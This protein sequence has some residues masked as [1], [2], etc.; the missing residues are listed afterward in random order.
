MV[1]AECFKGLPFE[2]ESF[3]VEKYDSCV[4]TCRYI[5]IFHATRN[6]HY[7]LIQEKDNLL[8]VI[9]YDSREDTVTCLN[10]L[11]YLKQDTIDVFTNHIFNNY[12][13]IKTIEF[14]S[15]YSNLLAEKSILAL[16]S[17]DFI[18]SLPPSLD[19]Y[20]KQLGSST[21]A[22]VRKHKNKFLK[23]NPQANF[24][25]KTG[26]EIDRNLIDKIISLNFNRII[27]KG[28][29][30]NVNSTHIDNFH[31]YS[32]HYGCV[33]YIEVN[34]SIIAGSIAYM[35][36]KSMYSYFLAHDNDYSNYNAGQLCM[37]YLI[38]VAIEKGFTE[39][40]LLWGESEYKTRFL[41]KPRTMY[42]YIIFKSFSYNFI[43]NKTK[44]YFSHLLYDFKRS[45]YALPLKS[46][47]RYFKKKNFKQLN[48]LQ[49]L[50]ILL[51]ERVLY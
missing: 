3:L 50:L 12:P 44:E 31:Q 34:G 39:F 40:H 14:P 24:V 19:D 5:A 15:S 51:F 48:K 23:E 28:Q 26:N 25:T 42:S 18:I 11:S 21:R 38:Q 30:P 46:A 7:M 8:D 17:D 2:Y 32:Q 13:N 35:S 41:A 27:S 4:T 16:R 37:L 10:S 43:F 1:S 49:Y 36:N 45:K 47:L 6:H 20:F 29:V 22:N 9:I 33:A